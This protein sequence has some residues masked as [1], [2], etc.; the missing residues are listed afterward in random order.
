MVEKRTWNVKFKR[1]S[2]KTQRTIAHVM[3]VDSD[4]TSSSL[5]ETALRLFVLTACFDRVSCL[6]RRRGGDPRYVD[7]RDLRRV[8]GSQPPRLRSRREST[9]GSRVDVSRG[10]SA[11]LHALCPRQGRGDRPDPAGLSPP[12]EQ[13]IMQL[14]VIWNSASSILCRT[15]DRT[16]YSPLAA[17]LRLATKAPGPS[18]AY[19]LYVATTLSGTAVPTS[20]LLNLPSLITT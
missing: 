11:R 5:R 10:E 9:G 15:S 6:V 18:R 12:D 7:G 16:R 19:R 2:V 17:A 14:T 8:P 13:Y 20:R 4:G 1:S 3:A